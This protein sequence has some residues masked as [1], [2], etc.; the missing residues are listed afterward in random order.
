MTPMKVRCQID[1]HWSDGVDSYDDTYEVAGLVERV[2]G[3]NGWADSFSVCDVT[4]SGPTGDLATSRAIP[5]LLP[6]NW[7]DE[8]EEALCEKAAEDWCNGAP[9]RPDPPSYRELYGED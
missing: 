4:I 3:G 6:S 8:A 5:E 2:P 1:L 9:S 7:L